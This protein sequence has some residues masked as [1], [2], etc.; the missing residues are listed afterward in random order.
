MGIGKS[1][2]E[3]Q[4]AKVIEKRKRMQEPMKRIHLV[5]SILQYGPAPEEDEVIEQRLSLNIEGRLVLSS[6]TYTG[7][8][9]KRQT[10]KVPKE[11]AQQ[12]IE[13]IADH[14]RAIEFLE[15]IFDAGY[16]DL[17]MTSQ[18]GEMHQL[19]GP[20]TESLNGQKAISDRI[21]E[22]LGMKELFLFDG[23]QPEEEE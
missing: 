7:A 11:I 14:F 8:V 6:H 9:I 10:K 20:T 15:M 18:T 2:R 17:K 13:E 23:G 12:A 3:L 19:Y 1:V 21:R 4:G 5:T 22:L 16:W